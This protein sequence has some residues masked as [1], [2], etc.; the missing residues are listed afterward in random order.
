MAKREMSK[1]DTSSML[2]KMS[3]ST[4]RQPNKQSHGGFATNI[5]R[6]V[7]VP[8]ERLFEAFVDESL[9]D[10]WLSDAKLRV[11]TAE[12]PNSLRADLEDGT[13]IVVGFTAKGEKRAQ[14]AL[15]HEKLP[16]SRAVAERRAYWQEQLAVLRQLLE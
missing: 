9:R 7:A 5:T 16:G 2:P 1:A 13:R 12:P 6:I 15:V 8:V 3:D 4:L 14:L 10:R 11:H